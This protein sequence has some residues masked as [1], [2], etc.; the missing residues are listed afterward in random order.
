[1]TSIDKAMELKASAT[2]G[3]DRTLRELRRR[4][5]A[6]QLVVN[7]TGQ[8]LT[9]HLLAAVG[10]TPFIAYDERMF[11][12]GPMDAEGLVID[13]LVLGL[14]GPDALTRAAHR[15]V[16]SG[17]PWVLN[18]AP[19]KFGEARV[20]LSERLSRLQPSVIRGNGM[21]LYGISPAARSESRSPG[22]I[23][24]EEA[25]DVA[26]ELAR[27]S[28]AVVAVTGDIDYV[29]DGQ[30]LVAV[31]NG[32]PLLGR[33]WGIGYALSALICA[34]CA[35]TPDPYAASVHALTMMSVAGELA[36]KDAQGP[37]SYRTRLLDIL[38]GLDERVLI[39]KAR[40]G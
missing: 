26:D 33:L 5:P 6:V 34:C 8:G 17:S 37:A 29:T 38:Y 32:D 15:A 9:V 10:A 3:I 36:A 39:E 1:M 24:S 25:L 23:S 22:K 28:A 40:I 14:L 35:V 12:H 18:P 31:V 21:S 13:P 4:S 7:P 19:P 30:G 11:D 16:E 2:E 27:D 20:E